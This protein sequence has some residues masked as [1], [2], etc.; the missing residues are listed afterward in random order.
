[1]Q[2][3]TDSRSRLVTLVPKILANEKY[4]VW[5][6]FRPQTS[7]WVQDQN[8][9]T[10]ATTTEPYL[11]LAVDEAGPRFMGPVRARDE[12]DDVALWLA[13]VVCMSYD[14][15]L[16]DAGACL[17]VTGG[18]NV[19]PLAMSQRYRGDGWLRKTVARQERPNNAKSVHR[20]V[21]ASIL[22]DDGFYDAATFTAR[23]RACF[24]LFALSRFFATP[25]MCA[26]AARTVERR[27]QISLNVNVFEDEVVLGAESVE[28]P[29]EPFK[30][31]RKD[32]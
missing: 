13:C 27:A 11:V 16:S 18:R 12:D 24:E 31:P 9:K 21:V 3:D 10:A 26:A 17:E 22:C 7:T 20:D 4:T 25:E 23:M 14:Y 28:K 1:M 15:N 30:R 19:C 2:A 6:H 29:A 8:L 5:T 32:E